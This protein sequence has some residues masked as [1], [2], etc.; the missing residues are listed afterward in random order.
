MPMKK[1]GK[2][3]SAESSPAID[4]PGTSRD[5][6]DQP[7]PNPPSME[8][9]SQVTPVLQARR[10][11][12]TTELFS[13][14]RDIRWYQIP[15]SSLRRPKARLFSFTFQSSLQE[16]QQLRKTKRLKRGRHRYS[17]TGGAKSSKKASTHREESQAFSGRMRTRLQTQRASARSLA[18][19]YVFCSGTA[20]QEGEPS[21]SSSRNQ[22]ADLSPSPQPAQASDPCGFSPSSEYTLME[23]AGSYGSAS[24]WADGSSS[25]L[26]EDGM[27]PVDWSPPRIE[28]LY[29]EDPPVLS[30]APGPTS[31]SHSSEEMPDIT[32]GPVELQA[33]EFLP[34]TSSTG[35][36]VEFL[37]EAAQPKAATWLETVSGDVKALEHFVPSSCDVINVP[38]TC[39]VINEELERASLLD[40]TEENSKRAV[41][42]E[43]SPIPS[44]T[45]PQAASPPVFSESSIS[46]DEFV[47][48]P[49][50]L[51]LESYQEGDAAGS[52]CP[53]SP[54]SLQTLMASSRLSPQC[55]SWAEGL[56][57][58]PGR[59]SLSLELEEDTDEDDDDSSLVPLED[60]FQT[61]SAASHS[62]VELSTFLSSGPDCYLNSLD[63]LLEEKR[64]QIQEDEELERSLGEKLLL[65]SSLG[66]MEV[67][68]EAE[69]EGDML[70]EAHRLLLEQFSSH[71]G[72]IPA[73]HPGESIFLPSACQRNAPALETAGLKPRNLLESL[74]F[75]SQF[76]QRMALLQDGILGS[77][78]RNLP[79]CPHPVLLWL[80]QLMS[81]NPDVST[82]AFQALWEIRIGQLT[83]ADEV[84]ADLWCPTLQDIIQ[85]FYNLGA[86]E[87]ALYPDGLVPLEFRYEDLEFRDPPP[88][89]QGS[90][91]VSGGSL[92]P[93]APG[94]FALAAMLGDIFKF[95]TLCVVSLPH[96]YPDRQRLALLAL[97]C[98]LSLDRNLREQPQVE[99][100]LLLLA[101]TEGIRDWQ[102]KLP[103]LVRMLC[104]LSLHH[105]NLVAVMRLFPDTTTRGRQL[106]RNL[107]LC[108]IYKLLGKM[109]MATSPWQEETQLQQ[110]GH[111]LPLLK[112]A[113]L[114]Q[115]L[116][117]AQGVP[118]QPGKEQK[119]ALDELDREACYLCY[120]LLKL[121]NVVVGTHSGSPREQGHLQKLCVQLQRHISTSIRED[122]CLMYRTELKN[123]VVHTYIKWQELFS[124][125]WPQSAALQGQ[126]GN[127]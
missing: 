45:H 125:G 2:Q 92:S 55:S 111:L 31:E 110:L 12:Y 124:R 119:E 73:V 118:G 102:E 87:S 10:M 61:S 8:T 117:R 85:A 89:P 98:R 100:Q 17:S 70:P 108:F 7:G 105:H 88:P 54:A 23:R 35:G 18:K 95:L 41:D 60:L 24:T 58:R 77:L 46:G 68:E 36:T 3:R 44:P 1:K 62:T 14:L 97:L 76:A 25:S 34:E 19:K 42:P 74:F 49:E 40:Q 38:S 115:G 67:E 86:C 20:H 21:S 30:P 37:E 84:G 109:Q 75:G 104:H 101:L 81:L 123:L 63:K 43:G 57:G 33:M 47:G 4:Q 6:A 91:D 69:E 9:T 51:S 112:L 93:E 22:E 127:I 106:R 15:L 94:P 28:F 82:D 39:E 26:E 121:A 50:R 103:E 78:Y 53:S 116:R 11:T 16:Y 65:S 107:S 13:T 56:A 113:F 27:F 48:D 59:L 96:C 120:S 71:Q 32:D 83:S 64:E 80:F 5:E 122:A 66:T 72:A 90:A 52:E 126:S 29:D 114:K 99:L 79:G